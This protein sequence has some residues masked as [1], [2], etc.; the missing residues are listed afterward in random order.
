M[1]FKNSVVSGFKGYFDFS[2]R[3]SRSEYWFWT[4][5]VVIGTMLTII[6]DETLFPAYHLTP[7]EASGPI[8]VTFALLTFFP[9]FAV[10]VRRIH[11]VNRSGWWIL[12]SV[13]IIGILFP[14]LYWSVK[15]GTEGPNR[16]GDDP[17]S[18]Y[19]G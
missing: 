8:Y 15:K 12:I 6:L 9:S 5:F 10:Y 3:A 16:F 4:L 7:D 18:F 17:L 2:G 14:L 1:N 13:T 19:N 11:D